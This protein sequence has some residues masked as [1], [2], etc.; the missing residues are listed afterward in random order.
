MVRVNA[1]CD[2][3]RKLAAATKLR[4]SATAR[5]ALSCRELRLGKVSRAMFG[6][7]AARSA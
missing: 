6:L 7:V 2:S 4:Y 1:G 3:F 5:T